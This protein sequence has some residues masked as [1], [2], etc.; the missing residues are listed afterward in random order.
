MVEKNCF[1]CLCYGNN[2]CLYPYVRCPYGNYRISLGKYRI[3]AYSLKSI[4]ELLPERRT[5]R[6]VTKIALPFRPTS[7]ELFFSFL[8]SI[9][10]A[11]MFLISFNKLSHLCLNRNLLLLQVKFDLTTKTCKEESTAG[12]SPFINLDDCQKECSGESIEWLHEVDEVNA[13][14]GAIMCAPSHNFKLCRR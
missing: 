4:N 1:F 9:L 12:C 6:N 7:P 5:S 11:S 13:K 2:C 3:L 10:I 8:M 14:S